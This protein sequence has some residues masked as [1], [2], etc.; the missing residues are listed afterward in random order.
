[1]QSCYGHGINP[2]EM[3]LIILGEQVWSDLNLSEQFVLADL[4]T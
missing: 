4:S 3:K 2:L 1:M